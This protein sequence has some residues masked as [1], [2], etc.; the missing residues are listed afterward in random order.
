MKKPQAL[1]KYLIESVR[2]LARNPEK[3]QVFIDAGSLQTRLQASLHFSYYY[4]LNIIITD[5]AEHPDNVLV[6]MLAWLKTNQT[7][8]KDNDIKFR[9]DILDN[10]KVD[11]SITLPLDERVLVQQNEDG[12]Y[13]TEHLGE[14]MLE[15]NLPTPALFKALY[16]N[17]SLLTPDYVED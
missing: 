2:S 11:L 17:E 15:H 6:P 16:G 1:R 3:L 12:N 8:L 9:A 7:D 4:T 13:T 10:N 14:P 5:F